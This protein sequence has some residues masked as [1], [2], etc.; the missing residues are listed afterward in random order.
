MQTVHAFTARFAA[1]ASAL[2][3]SLALF[4]VTVGAPVSAGQQPASAEL[5]A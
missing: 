5:V 4:S 3:L 1:A 2:A